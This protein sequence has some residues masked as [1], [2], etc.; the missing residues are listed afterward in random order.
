MKNRISKLEKQISALEKEI[1]EIDHELLMNYDQTIAQ[2]NFFD[3]YQQKKKELE[4]L[5]EAWEEETEKLEKQGD[6]GA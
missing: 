2:P 1:A 6:S 5:M 3:G 4:K